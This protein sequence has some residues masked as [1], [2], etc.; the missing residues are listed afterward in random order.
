MALSILSISWF[1]WRPIEAADEYPPFYCFP[2][3]S[4]KG[5][6][7]VNGTT[8]SIIL[9]CVEFSGCECPGW[10][11]GQCGWNADPVKQSQIKM[12]EIWKKTFAPGESG[13]CT[14]S[15]NP[16]EI[17]A[18]GVYQVDLFTASG[19]TAPN[20]WHIFSKCDNCGG[21][22]PTPSTAL[23]PSPTPTPS[24]STCWQQCDADDDCEGD[25]VCQ[26]TSG[27]KR[28]LNKKCETESDCTCNKNCW[29]VC[30]HDNECPSGLSCKQIDDTKRCVK[31]ECDREQDCNCAAPTPP[32]VLGEEAP[33]VLP[34]AGF[35]WDK[36]VFFGGLVLLLRFLAAAF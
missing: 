32:S 21:V 3:E 6:R 13:F 16:A 33:P 31:S 28:C 12:N 17:T 30:G 11:T 20:C 18:C 27:T 35:G 9:R 7:F 29:D 23:T 4:G 19:D 22:T 36:F 24:S 26:E 1:V 34:A 10:P 15:F 8:E 5:F 2:D 25:L 14:Y